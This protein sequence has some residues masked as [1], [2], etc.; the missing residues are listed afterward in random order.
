MQPSWH[1]DDNEESL[2]KL[3]TYPKRAYAAKNQSRDWSF[4][5]AITAGV[6]GAL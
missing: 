3:I 5:Y 6:F 2:A 4:R 1:R